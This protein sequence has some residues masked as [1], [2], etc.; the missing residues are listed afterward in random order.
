MY[1]VFLNPDN[2]IEVINEGPKTPEEQADTI[3]QGKKLSEQLRKEG[4]TVL[5]FDDLSKM[6]LPSEQLRKVG[7][8]LE[9]L[10]DFD[11][12]AFF[13]T[14]L[15]MKIMVDF[16]IRAGGEVKTQVFKNREEAI[17]WLKS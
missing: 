5:V 12:L 17:A 1:K 3:A 10:V 16:M 2:I 4:K 11:K 14:D 7:S 8:T 13:T 6:D 15:Q 9:K